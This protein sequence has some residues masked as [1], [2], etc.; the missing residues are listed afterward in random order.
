VT[1]CDLCG[2]AFGAE[3]RVMR[4]AVDRAGAGATWVESAPPSRRDGSLAYFCAEH[5]QL[6]RTLQSLLPGRTEVESALRGDLYQ[7]LD[8]LAFALEMECAEA[9]EAGRETEAAR[10]QQTRLGVRLAQRLVGS[11]PAP[12]IMDRLQ[13]WR[14]RYIEKFPPA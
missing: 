13:R 4:L 11:V 14:P 2:C 6:I 1:T 7:E 9:I 3:A 12:E 5:V 10:A 8:L